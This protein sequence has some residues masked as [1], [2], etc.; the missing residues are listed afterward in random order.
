MAMDSPMLS[1]RDGNPRE[2]TALSVVLPL[3]DDSS[4]GLTDL[5]KGVV[6]GSGNFDKRSENFI[7]A[8]INSRWLDS[9]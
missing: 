5:I 8:T 6:E 2:P 9:H 1:P 3:S 7:S 4:D